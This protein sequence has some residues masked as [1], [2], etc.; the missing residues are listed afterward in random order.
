M[1]QLDDGP[2]PGHCAGARP[3]A[4]EPVVRPALTDFGGLLRRLRGLG[5]EEIAQIRALPL[6]RS[7]WRPGANL[8]PDP[9]GGHPHIVLAGWASRQRVLRDGRRL[10][11]DFVVAGDCFG[12]APEAGAPFREKMVAVTAVEAVDATALF[13]LAEQSGPQSALAQALEAMRRE[14]QARMFDHMVRLGRLTAPEKVAHFLLEMDRRTVTP[15]GPPSRGFRLPLT[16]EAIG[17]T[18]GLSVVHVNRVLRQ[19]RA[20]KLIALREGLAWVLEPEKLAALAVL[21]PSLEA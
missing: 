12:G 4:S 3:A 6:V 19:L 7:R 15:G 20:D 14:D 13:G 5:A 8:L 10:I 21:E 1:R 2:R 9:L 17:D 16:Q 11:L 18:L